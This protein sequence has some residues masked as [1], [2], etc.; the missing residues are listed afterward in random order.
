MAQKLGEATVGI[1]E[2]AK[3][4]DTPLS[5]QSLPLLPPEMDVDDSDRYQSEIEDSD[6]CE[7]DDDMMNIKDTDYIPSTDSSDSESDSEVETEER[8]YNANIYDQDIYADELKQDK[9]IVFEDNLSEL[10]RFCMRCGSPITKCKK[11]KR[12]CV[13]YSI[14]CHNGCRYTWKSQ[15][16]S[17]SLLIAS[18]IFTTGNTYSKLSSFARALNLKFIGKTSYQDHQRDN[19]IPVV[20]KVW[21]E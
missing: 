7:M 10:L 17:S 21:Q 6:C 14:E 3:D 13:S 8:T 2:A 15:S 11:I 19:I 18:S 12:S 4:Q 1:A 16:S 5:S 9:F 20:Q